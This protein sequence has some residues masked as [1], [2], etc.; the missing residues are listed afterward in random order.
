MISS[1]AAGPTSFLSMPARSLISSAF[2]FSAERRL[3]SA[4]RKSSASPPVKSAMTIAMRSSCSWK[5]GTP[6]VRRSTPLKEWM[7]IGNF[8]P[9]LPPLHIWVHHFANDGSGPD[10]CDLYY[11]VIKLFLGCSEEAKPFVLAIRPERDRWCRLYEAKHKHFGHRAVS[12]RYLPSCRN[13]EE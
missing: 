8:L 5:S 4:L 12:A 7:R 6:S 10:N 1:C 13:A 2:I 9:S 11:Q 3:P